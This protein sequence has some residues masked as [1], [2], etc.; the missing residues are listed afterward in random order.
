MLFESNS[1]ML[2]DHVLLFGYV[3]L[4]VHVLHVL[5][6]DH[7]LLFELFELLFD[8]ELHVLL[9]ELFVLLF[10]HVLLFELDFQFLNLSL[11]DFSIFIII[12]VLLTYE[13]RDGL[14]KLESDISVYKFHNI[15]A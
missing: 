11:I 5:L 13:K 1:A 7:E 12:S 8:H 6:F 9:F 2:F 14:L 3:L 4:F 10:D 15:Y